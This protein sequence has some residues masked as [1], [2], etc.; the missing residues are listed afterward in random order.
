MKIIKVSLMVWIS[1]FIYHSLSA[2]PNGNNL[3]KQIDELTNDAIAKGIFSGTVVITKDGEP[4]YKKQSGYADWATKR[5]IADNTLYN[6]GSLNKQFTEEMIRQLVKEQKLDYNAS[7][8][9]Y[10]NLLPAETGNKITI[11]QLLDMRS[12]LGDYFRSP[13]FRDLENTNFQLSDILN[14]IKIEPLF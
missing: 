7:L 2:Q 11:Q 12:G 6:I 1:L 9:K 3:V 4:F 5:P 13:E 8:S 10:I 14:I